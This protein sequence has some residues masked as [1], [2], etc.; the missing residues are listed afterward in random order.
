M[1]SN[2]PT[3][4]TTEDLDGGPRDHSLCSTCGDPRCRYCY[5][6]PVCVGHYP[7]CCD[8]PEPEVEDED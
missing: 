2:Y 6:C 4:V 3:G 5:Q 7:G 1:A 8:F